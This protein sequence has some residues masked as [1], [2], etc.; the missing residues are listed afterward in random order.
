MILIMVYWEILSGAIGTTS[1]YKSTRDTRRSVVKNNVSNRIRNCPLI[2][3]KFIK[4]ITLNTIVIHTQAHSQRS[5]IIAGLAVSIA[6]AGRESNSS[7]SS[8]FRTVFFRLL[9]KTEYFP[10]QGSKLE[11]RTI[12]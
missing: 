10:M 5:L 6:K 3:A 12:Q 9:L 4:S 2:H 1:R 8:V 7:T 11:M